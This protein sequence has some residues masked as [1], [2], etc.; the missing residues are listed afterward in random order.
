VSLPVILRHEAEVDVQEARDQFEAIR[1]RRW[2]RLAIASYG[3]ASRL[4]A[5]G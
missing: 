4:V 5:S 1:T 3:T 2:S